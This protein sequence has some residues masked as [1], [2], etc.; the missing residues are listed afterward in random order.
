M[1]FESPLLQKKWVKIL[2]HIIDTVLLVSAII[3]AIQVSQYPL[4]DSWLTAKVL[5]L[6]VYI[7]LGS[8]ALKRGKTKGIRVTAGIAAIATFVYMLSVAVTKNTLGLFIFFTS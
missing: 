2:P 4:A 3:L 5:A 1:V 7:V 6:L 8:I